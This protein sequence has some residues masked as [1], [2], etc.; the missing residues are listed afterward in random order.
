MTVILKASVVGINT[1]LVNEK[2]TRPLIAHLEEEAIPE[3]IAKHL[4]ERSFYYN[5]S[6]VSVKQTI[7]QWKLMLRPQE[8]KL[9]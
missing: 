4:F 1:T 8:S 5:Q 6:K 3:F 2:S 7:K 9:V